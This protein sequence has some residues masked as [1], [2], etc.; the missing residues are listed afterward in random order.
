MCFKVDG[1]ALK[2]FFNWKKNVMNSQFRKNGLMVA[3]S[4]GAF[5][6]AA[7]LTLAADVV[8]IDALSN[9]GVN[10]NYDANSV[11]VS[12]DAG[13]WLLTPTNPTIDSEALFTAFSF[14]SDQHGWSNRARLDSDLNGINNKLLGT[15]GIFPT[16]QAAFDADG[17]QPVI[18][19]LAVADTVEFYI[20]DSYCDDNSGGISIRIEKEIPSLATGVNLTAT[21]N[22]SGGV[23]LT[24]TTSAEPDTAALLILRGD[25]LGNGGTEIDVACGFAS[26]GSP[27]TCTDDSA[28][29]TY[30]VVEMEYDGSLITYDEV[31]PK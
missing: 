17:N 31:T 14:W 12:L 10:P 28:A 30:R 16:P 13:K 4:A 5:A 3:L 2:I 19:E 8:N 25:K 20:A 23:D 24:L 9:C 1:V 15:P 11:D 7:P 29:D 26:G 6:L 21:V 22:E 18:L 27:Y